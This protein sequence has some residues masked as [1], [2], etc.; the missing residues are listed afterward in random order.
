[1][2]GT[3]YVVQ[4]V[5]KRDPATGDL[6]PRWDL[7]PAERFGKLVYLLGPRAQ[8]GTPESILGDLRHG[9][10]AYDDED[11]ILPIGDPCF[12]GW[13]IAIAADVNSKVAC[14][15]WDGVRRDYQVI[16]ADVFPIDDELLEPS[17]YGKNGTYHTS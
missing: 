5:V 8:P 2:S 12:I 3:V 9:L 7:G 4:Q 6:V 15:R 1:M 14:L 16:I 10:R 13:A 11:F 17:G